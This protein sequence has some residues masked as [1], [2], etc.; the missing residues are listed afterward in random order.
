MDANGMESIPVT[1]TST[2]DPDSSDGRYFKVNEKSHKG[3]LQRQS[4]VSDGE[5]VIKV[6]GDANNQKFKDFRSESV[7][8][9][10]NLANEEE[11]SRLIE[12][13]LALQSTLDDLSQ[14]VDA[15]KDENLKLK[16][17]NQVLGQYIENLMA[18]SNV[19]Q[20]TGDTKGRKGSTRQSKKR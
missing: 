4:P 7:D 15:V 8:I 19:F 9:Q 3:E 6:L 1:G 17:E 5:A 14:R 18:A 10:E 13:V 11:R 2:Q 20:T 16:S 12:Q